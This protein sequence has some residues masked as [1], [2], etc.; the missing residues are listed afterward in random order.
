MKPR[1]LVRLYWMLRRRWNYQ[2]SVTVR[3]ARG[4]AGSHLMVSS[5]SPNL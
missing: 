1:T 4:V 5:R 2:Q 3:F